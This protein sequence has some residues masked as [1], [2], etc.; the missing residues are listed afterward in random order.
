MFIMK[1]IWKR[2]CIF[3]A[4]LF[5]ATGCNGKDI[6]TNN[7]EPEETVAVSQ[8]P[9]NE[10]LYEQE[11]NIIDDNYRSYYEVFL[12][13]Y[14]DSDGDGIGDINGL[15][16]KLD[17]IADL[18]YNGIWL[19]PIMQSTTYHKYDVVDYY[20]I[21]KEYGTIEDFKKLLAECDQRGIKVIMDLV[22]NHTSTQNTWFKTATEYLKNLPEGASPSKE[23][24]PY[25]D[26]YNFVE[27]QPASSDYHRVGTTDW[28]YECVFW[29]QMPDLN[30]ASKAVRNEVE[31]IA[32][33]WLELGVG[34]FRLDA[35][36]EFY[37]GQLQK[38]V[39]VLEWFNNYVSEVDEDAYIVAEVWESFAVMSRYYESGI[40]SLFNF[41]FSQETGKIATTLNGNAN[42]G[43]SFGSAMVKVQENFFKY[44]EKAI[45]APFFTNHDT[46]RATGYF[47]NEPVKTKMAAGMNL[48]MSGSTFTYYGEEIGMSSTGTKDENKR[49][50]MF[51][52]EADSSGMTKGPGNMD[53]V[54]YNFGSVE[55][56]K[57]DEL[58]IYNYYKRAVRLRNENPEIARGIVATLDDVKD[59]D[60]C[61]I[62][63][64]YNDSKIF[65]LYNISNNEK[66]ITLSKSE[67]GYSEIRG[68]LSTDG[69]PVLLDGETLTLP[70]YSIVV[71]K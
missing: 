27:G 42:S 15:I 59:M 32:S 60:I 26:Y 21:D 14:C 37:S 68:Y 24:C 71:L 4:A 65:I 6:D 48:M 3:V 57:T 51:W 43:K 11:L 58:S 9:K 29:D 12:Y 55:D 38:N 44:N 35:A 20:S 70:A 1:T 56:Q 17:Y 49:A 28:Y 52:S 16:S 13:S 22:F 8:E 33:F 62:S 66:T 5:I 41:P 31:E 63:K 40:G 64:T 50:P 2:V 19:M 36:K 67:H 30:L 7:S 39:E 18:G 47:A 34:G 10:Y 53:K 61:A 45:D 46:G 25:F 54:P 23:D 69:N